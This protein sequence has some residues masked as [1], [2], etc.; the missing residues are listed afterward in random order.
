MRDPVNKIRKIIFYSIVILFL[1]FAVYPVFAINEP[2]NIVVRE[3]DIEGLYSTTKDEIVELLG[4]KIGEPLNAIVLSKGIK[5]VFLKGIFEDIIVETDDK[6]ATIVRIK[7]I[8]RDVIKNIS[9][10]GAETLSAKVIKNHFL[11]KEEQIMRYDLVDYAVNSL[12]QALTERGYPNAEVSLLIEKTKKPHKI[13]LIL[14][15]SEGQPEIIKNIQIKGHEEAKKLM[16]L[17]E[18]D[19]FDQ[20]RLKDDFNRI[21]AYYKK[22]SHLNPLIVQYSFHEGVLSFTFEPG[23]KLKVIFEGNNSISSKVLLK[24]VPFFDIGELSDDLIDESVSRITSVYYSM[25]YPYAQIAPVKI[26]GEGVT[27][28]IYYVYEG[29]RVIVNSINFNG[30]TISETKLKDIISLKEGSGYNP[31]IID[32]D[33]DLLRE[34]YYALGY[35]GVNI[36]DYHVEIKDFRA[37]INITIT[38]GMKTT[39][40]NIVISGANQVPEEEIRKTIKLKQGDP[41][42]EVDISDARYEIIDLYGKHGFTGTKVNIKQTLHEQEMDIIFEIDEGV[43]SFFGKTIVSGN[44]KTKYKAI[45]RELLYKEGENFNYSLLSKTRQKM[46][47]LG[48]FT[49]VDVEE[50]QNDKNIRN[51]HIK[52]IE[53]N[54]GVVE[55]GFGYG[56]YE[57]YRFLLDVSYRNLFG[58]NRQP[59]FRTEISSLEQRYIL[60][61]FEPWF[62]DKPIPLRASIM[63]EERT[64]K[65]FETDEIRYKLKRYATSIGMEKKLSEKVKG[66]IYYEFSQTKTYDVD[67]DVILSKEDTGY[68]AISSIRPGLVYDS[69]DNPFDP[70]KGVLAGITV[71]AASGLILSKTDFIKTI[72]T[73]SIYQGIS[74]RFVI[75]A[76]VKSG[77]AKSLQN[78]IELPLVE[79]FF[80]GGRN[81]VRGY[82]QDSLGPKGA[83]GSPTG[84]NAFVLTNLELR[85]YLG[86]GFGMVNFFDGGNVWISTNDIEL[87]EMRYTV[88][89]GI[90]YSTP[91]GP[92]RVDYGYK[93][94][95]DP[96]EKRGAIHFSIGHAF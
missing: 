59:S 15:I 72:L 64:E 70:K 43:V 49:D 38:E 68:L 83:D 8:E 39:I 16:E 56:D 20:F 9:V 45:K 28:I 41:Y 18:G 26:T 60:N 57:K 21:K 74:R 54:A 52:V 33:M 48:L 87:S 47:K 84:G 78:T 61:Y 91:V 4:I 29:D 75:A 11:F 94:K 22:N 40:R 3:I 81:T 67:P 55:F 10:K 32:N 30:I 85:T 6:D 24:E 66:E 77:L 90:R 42:N 80:L 7:I 76:S 37:H 23:I 25:G 92:L 50:L 86:R 36:D 5:L 69:R 13:N 73:G 27:M 88:G 95:K 51:V 1:I 31:D 96:D 53:G 35:L 14:N 65:N 12:R 17:T 46:Y 93:L 89:I 19:I 2:S 82:E 44:T 58:M 34:F 79:R 63:W 62:L 71:K